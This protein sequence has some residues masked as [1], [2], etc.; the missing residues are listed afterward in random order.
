LTLALYVS[1][2]CIANLDAKI[3]T[4]HLEG[5]AGK[6]GFVVGYDPVQDP[7]LG[8]DGLDELDC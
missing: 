5:I 7:K 4:V 6:L 3:F 2:R 1:N 8:D